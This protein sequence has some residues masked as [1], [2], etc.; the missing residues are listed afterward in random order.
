[1]TAEQALKKQRMVVRNIQY[2]TKKQ[3]KKIGDLEDY[4][5]VT[6]GYF[7]RL[8]NG[9]QRRLSLVLAILAAEFLECSIDELMSI[10]L[11]KEVEL[12]EIEDKIAKLQ[13]RKD[14]LT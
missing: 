5:L 1:M 6:R 8:G 10:D 9:S 4:C 14:E 13:K 3:G 2:L 11:A 12:E 7:S